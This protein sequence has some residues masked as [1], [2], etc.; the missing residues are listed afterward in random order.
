MHFASNRHR[1]RQG[2]FS[3]GWIG[4][5]KQDPAAK[6][7]LTLA[8]ASLHRRP[9]RVVNRFPISGPLQFPTNAGDGD[10]QYILTAGEMGN[11]A[12]RC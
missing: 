12:G 5:A 11:R 3:P 1:S 8:V 4:R 2:H 7:I 10:T 9:A 6:E